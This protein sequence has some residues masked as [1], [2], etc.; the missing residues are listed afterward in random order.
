MSFPPTTAPVLQDP[1]GGWMSAATRR[2]LTQSIALEESPVPGLLRSC[3]GVSFLLVSLF[4]AWSA[5]AEVEEVASAAGQIVPSGYIQDIQHLEGGIIR[6]ILVQEG[7]LV[8]K[9]Q[10][11]VKLDD[12]GANADLGQIRAKQKT[13]ELQVQRLRRFADGA[14]T[15]SLTGDEKAILDSMNAA[16]STQKDVLTAQLEQKRRE[17][18]AI[19]SNKA[20]LQ[21][22]VALARKEYD[23]NFQMEAKG[24]SSKLATLNAERQLNQ[25]VGQL[26]EATTQEVQAQSAITEAQSRLQSLD[27]SLR[28][29]A[30]KSLAEAQGELDELNKGLGKLE[31]A[32]SRTTVTS[33]VRGLVKGLSVHTLGAVIEPGKVLMEIVPVGEEL[34]VE[35]LVSPGDIGNIEKGEA[36]KVKVSAYDASRYGS[37]P[38][39]LLSVSASTFQTQ[40]GQSFYKARIQLAHDY[41][42][43]DA[44]RNLLLPG[45]AVQAN[46]IT[47]QKTVL[48]YLLRPL[49]AATEDAFHE[50]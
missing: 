30:L 4:L 6:E 2:R 37:V 34:I 39:K 16:R 21:K 47:G 35:A 36:V 43:E 18:D 49:K 13:L 11:L 5:V 32:A 24:S 23:I 12:T 48:E 50:K 1:A 25:L 20:A 9:G 7:D 8:E 41:V 26:N 10:P 38:G 15:D 19:S 14:G 22:N 31:N 46:I 45:M 27:A 3:V 17:L 33:P 42:G 40:E 28:Q 29:D 44:N